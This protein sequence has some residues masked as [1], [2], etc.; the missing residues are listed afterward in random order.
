MSIEADV[1][2]AL[3]ALATYELTPG[4]PE[5]GHHAFEGDDLVK[6]VGLRGH[7]L[8]DAVES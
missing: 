2:Q 7:R 5:R 4:D 3:L 1:T 8:R 6:V